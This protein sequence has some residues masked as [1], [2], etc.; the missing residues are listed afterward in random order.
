MLDDCW[1]HKWEERLS[2]YDLM[3]Q[4]QSKV[5]VY[6]RHLTNSRF[7]YSMSASG[8]QQGSSFFYKSSPQG[9][10]RSSPKRSSFTQKIRREHW[11]TSSSGFKFFGP[12]LKEGE[13]GLYSD[14]NNAKPYRNLSGVDPLVNPVA[15]DLDSMGHL[16]NISHDNIPPCLEGKLSERSCESGMKEKNIPLLASSPEG[17]TLT[18]QLNVEQ[19]ASYRKSRTKLMNRRTHSDI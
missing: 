14:W 6:G 16:N 7:S 19:E 1:A 18:L 13:G 4:L 2:F 17:D 8:S 11:R 10:R 3:V 12:A 9:S 15:H 5:K